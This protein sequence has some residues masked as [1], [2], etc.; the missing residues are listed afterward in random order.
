MEDP[1]LDEAQAREEKHAKLVSQW[2]LDGLESPLV[3]IPIADLLREGIEPIPMLLDDWLYEGELHWIYAEAEAWKTWVALILALDVMA[4]GKRVVWFDEEVGQVMLVQRL[5]ALG[6]DP[7]VIEAKFAY[8]P[9]PDLQ[10]REGNQQHIDVARH[11][12]L[13][14]AIKPALVVYDTATDFLAAAGLDENSGRE[15]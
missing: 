9:F 8:F 12:D 10:I 7:D 14:Q 4:Q 5:Q 11:K 3:P 2:G 6:A 13:L 15:V 1:V